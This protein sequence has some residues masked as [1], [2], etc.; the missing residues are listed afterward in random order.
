MEIQVGSYMDRQTGS[1]QTEGWMEV[2]TGDRRV[3]RRRTTEER[4]VAKTDGR[5]DVRIG[6]QRKE[7]QAM[8]NIRVSGIFL[9]TVNQH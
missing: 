8:D 6:R 9:I 5:I 4:T 2:Q 7:S 3:D 1:Q